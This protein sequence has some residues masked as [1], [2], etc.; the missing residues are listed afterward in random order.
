MYARWCVEQ[1]ASDAVAAFPVDTV[2]G[3]RPLPSLPQ[4]GA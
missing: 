4:T 1:I 2:L 3:A